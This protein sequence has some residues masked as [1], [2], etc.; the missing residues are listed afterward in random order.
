M[1]RKRPASNDYHS[2]FF[3]ESSNPAAFRSFGQI[4]TVF[5]ATT[6]KLHGSIDG[7]KL[8]PNFE[9]DKENGN[10][11]AIDTRTKNPHAPMI[12]LVKFQGKWCPGAKSNRSALGTDTRIFSRATIFST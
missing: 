9:N 1:G 6:C 11:N 10:K 5:V 2:H 7:D 12:Q 3:T 8:P 4:F